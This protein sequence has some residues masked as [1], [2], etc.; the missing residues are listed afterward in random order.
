[1]KLRCVW[2]RL[3]KDFNLSGC[4][5]QWISLGRY[6]DDILALSRWLCPKCT[7]LLVDEIHKGTVSFDESNEGLCTIGFFRVIKFLDLWVYF[8]WEDMRVN[9]SLRN[10]LFA[11]SGLGSLHSKNRFPPPSGNPERDRRRLTSDF[12]AHI[13]RFEQL[14]LTAT[15]IFIAVAI[16]FCEM[17]LCGYCKRAVHDSWH[18]ATTCNS[19]LRSIGQ[20]IIKAGGEAR[21]RP[22]PILHLSRCIPPAIMPGSH[23]S[24]GCSGDHCDGQRGHRGRGGS[25]QIP[26]SSHFDLIEAIIEF[27]RCV[28][29]R[30]IKSMPLQTDANTKPSSPL[31][32]QQ[33]ILTSLTVGAHST[34]P[35]AQQ[36]QHLLSRLKNAAQNIVNGSISNNGNKHHYLHNDLFGTGSSDFPTAADANQSPGLQM[37]PTT[38][39][40]PASVGI[41]P[42]GS[43]GNMTQFLFDQYLQNSIHFQR[44]QH[45][46]GNSGDNDDDSSTSHISDKVIQPDSHV[47]QWPEPVR[48]TIVKIQRSTIVRS[49]HNGFSEFCACQGNNHVREL[50]NKLEAKPM[51]WHTYCNVISKCKSKPQWRKKCVDHDIDEARLTACRSKED[52]IIVLYMI[53]KER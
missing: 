26:R 19:C 12:K 28:Q 13:A 8:S 45:L 24:Y 9:F 31:R 35:D 44:I 1:M 39:G 7:K 48:S 6:V 4:K 29:S 25:S 47:M 38:P 11:L 37:F 46:L 33:A 16:D 36:A 18:I 42:G 21:E 49:D 32:Q 30:S 41:M 52:L 5:E 40:P 15:Q 43:N 53:F 3:K 34:S 10:D 2:P 23:G 17:F 22:I 51:Q 50:G 20:Y 27:V 14:R